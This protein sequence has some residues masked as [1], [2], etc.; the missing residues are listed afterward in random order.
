ME[1]NELLELLLAERVLD[2]AA[3]IRVSSTP[4]GLE[5]EDF[6]RWRAEHPTT[7]FIPEALM[8]IKDAAAIIRAS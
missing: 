3:R 4:K 7:G 6:E 5:S 1:T 8:R 2:L